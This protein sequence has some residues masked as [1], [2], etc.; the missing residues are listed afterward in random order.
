MKS[1]ILF[2]L[3]LLVGLMFV[4]GGLNK[5][6]N[7]MPV[8]DDLPKAFVQMMQAM[9]QMGWLMPLVGASE[10]VAGVLFAIPRTRPLGAIM[11][12]PLMVGFF[13]P[14]CMLIRQR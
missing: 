1:K 9:M 14:I 10:I 13:W 8:P 3:C 5:F 4:N 6:L 2:V 12:F 11:L 7:Y